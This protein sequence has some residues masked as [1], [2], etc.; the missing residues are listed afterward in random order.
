MDI[1]A[2]EDICN[3]ITRVGACENQLIC[4][5]LIGFVFLQHS[6]ENGFEEPNNGE[7]LSWDDLEREAASNISSKR[8][9]AGRSHQQDSFRKGI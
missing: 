5:W 9:Q 8:S 7:E 3:E 4:L 6:E 1:D 2:F